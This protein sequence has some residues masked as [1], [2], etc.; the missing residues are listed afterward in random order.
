MPTIKIES[1]VINW[2]ELIKIKRDFKQ[3]NIITP[4]LFK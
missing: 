1:V 4:K 3:I 2:N